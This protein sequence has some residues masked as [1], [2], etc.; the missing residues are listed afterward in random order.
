MFMCLIIPHAFKVLFTY[1]SKMIN[2]IGDED[3]EGSTF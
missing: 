1:Q 2:F 3:K